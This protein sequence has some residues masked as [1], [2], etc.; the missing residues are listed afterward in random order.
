VGCTAQGVAQAR[1]GRP[2]RGV[3]GSAARGWR[4]ARGPRPPPASRPG[5]VTGCH[6]I[7]SG[8]APLRVRAA[9][10]GRPS[11]GARRRRYGWGPSPAPT[12]TIQTATPAM[13][14]GSSRFR[15]SLSV[16]AGATDARPTPA[17]LGSLDQTLRPAGTRG[18]P[19]RSA[20]VGRERPFRV[21]ATRTSS[22]HGVRR[23]AKN[24]RERQ[25]PEPGRRTQ[26][27]QKRP[28]RS[29]PTSQQRKTAEARSTPVTRIRTG[30]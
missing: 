9:R 5:C 30:A 15:L 26:R 20:P 11:S 17:D 13:Q 28:H 12:T 1:L 29:A 16:R 21:P 18:V 27:K 22:S 7:T 14:P 2:N 10:D 8:R 25:N 3:W 6:P 23:Q 24:V 19:R 4:L